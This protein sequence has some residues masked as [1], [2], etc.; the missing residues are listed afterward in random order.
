MG[1]NS[2]VCVPIKVKERV[3]GV[4]D[5][6]HRAQNAFKDIHTDILDWLSKVLAIAYSSEQLE[7]FIQDLSDVALGRKQIGQTVLKAL[8]KFTQADYGFVAIVDKTGKCKIKA[9]IDREIKNPM[10]IVKL[11]HGL[12]GKVLKS[13]K[14]C[15]IS[16]VSRDKSYY[17]CWENTISEIVLPILGTQKRVLGIINLE[18]KNYQDFKLIDRKL[19]N[20]M[21]KLV[22]PY[23]S[24]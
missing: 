21:A 18:F 11:G 1:I 13:G 8:M 12:T 2:E 17:P 16:D 23:I 5:V 3:V 19:F 9:I 15:Y 7:N 14:A 10:K 22:A 6:E 24:R 4:I 20:S